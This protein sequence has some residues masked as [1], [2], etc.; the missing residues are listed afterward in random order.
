MEEPE[1]YVL[2]DQVGHLLRRAYQRH[3]ALFQGI[4]GE[5]GPT[6]MQFAAL[7]MLWRRGPLSQNLLGR[8]LAMDPPTVKGVVARLMARGLVVRE[9]DPSDARML[10]VALTPA[11]LA[12][13]PG[14]VE[15]AKAVSAATLA[16]LP[17]D[18]AARLSAILRRMG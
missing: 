6:S 3:L 12:A 16:P 13:L 8:L 18:E 17:R 2:E 11:A 1:D 9:R 5:D 15:K 7:H 14:W 10:L 4:M